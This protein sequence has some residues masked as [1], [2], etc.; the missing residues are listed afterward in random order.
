[1]VTPRPGAWALGPTW[2]LLLCIAAVLA[3]QNRMW[4][5]AAL[6]G[7]AACLDL[8]AAATDADV[9]PPATGGSR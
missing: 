4:T 1:M 9:A 6:A 7:L 5:H 8:L 3:L 2:R